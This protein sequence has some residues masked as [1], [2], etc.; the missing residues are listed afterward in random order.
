M[1]IQESLLSLNSYPILASFIEKVGIDRNLDITLAY[2][3]VIAVSQSYELATA[4][5]Y[6][7]LFSC[8]NLKEQEVS[9]TIQ[10]R[11]DFLNTANS[12]YS[13]YNDTKFSGQRVG[14]KGENW[15]G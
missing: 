2:T 14:Y 13:K 6:K 10:E 1:T 9:L 8:P 7:W 15:N 3:S 12:I 4:D 5:V 11:T